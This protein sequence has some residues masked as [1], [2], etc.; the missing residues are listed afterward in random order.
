MASS[1]QTPSP[2]SLT[3][4]RPGSDSPAWDGLLARI[5]RLVDVPVGGPVYT[6][7]AGVFEPHR[8]AIRTEVLT[9][10]IESFRS[11]TGTD[12]VPTAVLGMHSVIERLE[13]LATAGSTEKASTTA[14]LQRANGNPIG[15]A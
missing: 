3:S 1:S 13:S 8:E 14:E 4:A 5:A 2:D 11:W 6:K 10:V 15:G 7:L 12:G 9:E